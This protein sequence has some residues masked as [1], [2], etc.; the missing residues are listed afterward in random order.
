MLQTSSYHR[1]L[2]AIYMMNMLPCVGPQS[3]QPQQAIAVLGL[4]FSGNLNKLKHFS[5]YSC[6]IKLNVSLNM[7][8]I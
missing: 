7:C 8:C 6:V 3:P 2:W 1:M 4:W 5:L